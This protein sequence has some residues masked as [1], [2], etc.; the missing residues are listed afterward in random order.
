VGAEGAIPIIDINLDFLRKIAARL[1]LQGCRNMNKLPLCDALVTLFEKR[2]KGNENEPMTN[3]GIII[4]WNN[5]RLLNVMFGTKMATRLASRGQLLDKDNLD[6]G[7]KIDKNLFLDFLV[8]YN[9]RSNE[10]YGKP[11]Y[12]LRGLKHPNEFDQYPSNKWEALKKQFNKLGSEYEKSLQRWRK[13][14]THCDYNDLDDI[15]PSGTTSAIM[16]YMHDYMQVNPELLSSCDSFLPPGL[17]NQSGIRGR[18][19]NQPPTGVLGTKS[20]GNIEHNI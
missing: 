17:S 8:E 11:A 19:T 2:E 12:D 15:S 6:N 10:A 3:E 5:V 4:R 1:L 13:S 20:G 14:G 9:D 7:I 16:F 18:H